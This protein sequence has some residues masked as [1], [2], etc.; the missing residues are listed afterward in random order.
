MA[1]FV[2]GDKKVLDEV[3][4][5]FINKH[6]VYGLHSITDLKWKYIIQYSLMSRVNKEF[7]LTHN[8]S[9]FYMSNVKTIWEDKTILLKTDLT[10]ETQDFYEKV[11]KLFKY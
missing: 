1:Q 4:I 6:P 5:P 2:V 10:L 11:L 9:E 7:K 8:H 3:I